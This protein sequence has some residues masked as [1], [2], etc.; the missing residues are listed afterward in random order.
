MRHEIRALKSS[1]RQPWTSGGQPT[2]SLDERTTI[3][4]LSSVKKVSKWKLWFRRQCGL[5]LDA[6]G[7]V[8][9][10]R[11]WQRQSD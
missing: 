6:S 9:I 3:M 1:L 8:I 4:D 10:I 11:H 2:T 7:Q 5:D